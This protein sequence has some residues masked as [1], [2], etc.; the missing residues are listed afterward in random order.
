MEPGKVV[1]VI[2]VVVLLIVGLYY[3]YKFLY[4]TT[5][6]DD[7]IVYQSSSGG[8]PAKIPANDTSS[9]NVF[10]GSSIVPYIYP[11]GEY[12]ISTW[13]YVKKWDATSNKPFLMLSNTPKKD[14][15]FFMTLVMYLGKTKNKLGIRMSYGETQLKWNL[16]NSDGNLINASSVYADSSSSADALNKFSLDIDSV[17]IQRWVNITTVITGKTVDVYMDGKLS[18]SSVL[19]SVF[20]VDT[21]ETP[22]I[23]LGHESGFNG[24]IGKTRAANIAYSPDRVYNYYQ[25]GPFSTFNLSSILSS[26]NPFQ[27]GITVTNNN[28]V[29]FSTDARK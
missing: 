28:S 17:D 15:E 13:I 14:N 11:G 18:R 3:A 26:L 27:Y 4:S 22:T 24:L 1:M 19:P 25:Q 23:T 12:S 6:I 29:M 16:L 2:I 10:S 9:S 7:L 5:G 20:T 21:G 8:L